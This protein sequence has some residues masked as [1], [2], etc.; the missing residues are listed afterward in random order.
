MGRKI[1]V[2]VM[3]IAIAVM[4][5]F[6][7]SRWYVKV[8]V[9]GG[10]EITVAYGE[11]FDDPGAA[12]ELE[13]PVSEKEL[14]VHSKGTVDTG[15]IGDYTIQ[16]RAGSGLYSGRAERVVHVEDETA[17]LLILEER[18]G[19]VIEG[20]S[21]SDGYHADDNVDGDLTEQ[22]R[23]EGHVDTNAPGTYVLHYSVSDAAGNVSEAERT[24]VVENYM[25]PLPDSKV[26]FLTFDDGPGAYTPELLEILAR[27]DVRVTFFVTA[28]NP[29]YFHC[30]RQA[31]EAGHTVAVHSYTHS[32]GGIYESDE[33]YW[34]DFEAMNDVIEEQTGQRADIFR[35]PGGSSNTVS[36]FNPGIMTRL[37]QEAGER[38]L[39]YFDW[40]VESGDAGRVDTADAVFENITNQCKSLDAQGYRHMVVLCHDTHKY[41]V[42]AMDRVLS[43][44]EE[45]GYTLYPLSKGITSCH[46][47][48]AN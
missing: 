22:V 23:V 41:T 6:I 13:G 27:H 26:V 18:P 33:A 36:N 12:A 15:R 32:Y 3:L 28:G 5:T 42:D 39:E 25:E 24:V 1:S 7:V 4:L 9:V 48:I 35:F 29:D 40:N 34:A 16:Y 46:H 47:G 43:W 14:E 17:P 19:A 2:F 20:E 30:M 11:E 8:D 37:S 38:G 21:W 44:F 10:E 45:N 31:R